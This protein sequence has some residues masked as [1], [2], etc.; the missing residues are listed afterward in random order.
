LTPNLDEMSRDALVSLARDLLAR[1]AGGDAATEQRLHD[2]Q[3]QKLELERKLQE[4]RRT[5]LEVDEARRRY[6]E[7]YDYSPSA[8]CAVDVE[9]RIEEVNLTAASLFAVDR[10]T[11]IGR[12]LSHYALPPDR[13]ALKRGIAQC[14][15][16][17][18]RVTLEVRFDVPGMSVVPF[19]IVATPMLDGLNQAIGCKLA[20][21]DVS[22]VKRSEQ[23]LKALANAS[24]TL[25]TSFDVERT[26]AAVVRSLT[27]ALSDVCFADVIDDDGEVRRVEVS[28][29]PGVNPGLGEALRRPPIPA[30]ELAEPLLLGDG[31]GAALALAVA[32]GPERAAIVELCRPSSI[33]MVPMVVRERMVGLIGLVSCDGERRYTQADLTFAVDLAA[34]GAVAIDSARIY[35]TATRAVEARQDMLSI[36]SHD[37]KTPLTSILLNAGAMAGPP[38]GERRKGKTHVD[39][40]KQAA[41]QMQRIIDDL[42]DATSIEAGNLSIDRRD[43]DVGLLM[44]EAIELLQPLGQE[45]GLTLEA[46][47]PSEAMWVACDATRVTQVFTN[48]IGNAVKFTP[49]GGS[50]SIAADAWEGKVRLSVRDNGPG[51]SKAVMRRLFERFSQ[52]RETAHKGRGLGL[53]ISKGIVEAQGGTIWVESQPGVGTVVQFTLPPGVPPRSAQRG[54]APVV[55]VVEPDGQLREMMREVLVSHGYQIALAASRAE[56][57]EYL[58]GTA[59]APALI[60]VDLGL[61]ARE[62]PELLSAL[63]KLP[64]AA[65]IPVVIVSGAEADALALGAVAHL[66]KPLDL[67]HLLDAVTARA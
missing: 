12:P 63:K 9:G 30:V 6:A 60:L 17:K 58:A 20:L 42:L 18:A 49:E 2:L 13:A 56:A 45:K 3:V 64:A 38:Q 21:V 7:L 15:R 53:F 34:R 33:I 59:S 10:A 22:G 48:L 27:P 46:K 28:V 1:L 8:N 14:V 16:E 61:P 23:R 54:P 62:G 19:Q 50:I 51:M 44:R 47:L 29:G 65:H 37:L 66:R 4:L 32:D 25:A 5:W 31:A 39:R 67:R 43:H 55:L 40:I 26:L 24:V 52:A 35:R 57:L 11:A 41:K 36:V